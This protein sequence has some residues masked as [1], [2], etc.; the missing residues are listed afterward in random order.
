M[1]NEVVGGT[2]EAR[3]MWWRV[4]YRLQPSV[5]LSFRVC[6]PVV[7]RPLK[8]AARLCACFCLKGKQLAPMCDS[9]GSQNPWQSRAAP[10]GGKGSTTAGKV[11][12]TAPP[13]ALP[14][15]GPTPV[16]DER[17]TT[18]LHAVQDTAD[19]GHRPA[20]PRRCFPN[21]LH[22]KRRATLSTRL[23]SRQPLARMVSRVVCACCA[24]FVCDLVC[25]A[26]SVC[27]VLCSVLCSV[28]Q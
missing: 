7:S 16:S 25:C 27:C 24:F 5:H 28:S 21:K 15:Q 11:G 18:A 1:N 3:R 4:G 20:A 22:L 19:D 9:R 23:W 13:T 14:A 12:L 26:V 17:V 2:N 6:R 10:S 8:A